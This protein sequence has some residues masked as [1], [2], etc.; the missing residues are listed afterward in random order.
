MPQYNDTV[1]DFNLKWGHTYALLDDR[2]VYIDAAYYKEN[3]PDHYFVSM[4]YNKR[5]E[6]IENLDFTLFTPILFDSQFF[7]SCDFTQEDPIACLYIARSSKRQNKRSI[8]S[9][10]TIV[11]SPLSPL[12]TQ[13]NFHKNKLYNINEKYITQILKKSFPVYKDALQLC[14]KYLM[15]AL[16]PDFAVSLSSISNTKYLLSSQFGFIGE[17]DA[18]CLYIH[19][20]G[21]VQEINDFVRRN[22]LNLRVINASHTI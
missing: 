21:S 13:I 18:E 11:V 17:A 16:S 9:E 4:S 10:N 5:S 19:H 8:C 15:V 22:N 14:D 3:E 6:H 12:I 20:P 1:E 2:I 7:N